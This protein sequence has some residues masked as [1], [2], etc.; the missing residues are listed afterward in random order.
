MGVAVDDRDADEGVV[1]RIKI[2]W[3]EFWTAPPRRERTE[4]GR[5]RVRQ[6]AASFERDVRVL[7]LDWAVKGMAG[8]GCGDCGG[9]L[10]HSAEAKNKG[11]RA[12]T[13]GT[14]KGTGTS[15]KSDKQLR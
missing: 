15:G 5:D 9:Q 4:T 8:E 6:V 7:G 10:R 14:R 11:G 2:R 3:G 12:L 13:T 1:A